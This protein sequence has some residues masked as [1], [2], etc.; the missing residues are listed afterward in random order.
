MLL[1]NLIECNYFSQLTT[2]LQISVWPL[3]ETVSP[4]SENTWKHC[5]SLLFLISGVDLGKMTLVQNMV[6][7]KY[8]SIQHFVSFVNSKSN[9]LL[10][11]LNKKHG[12]RIMRDN[13]IHLNSRCCHFPLSHSM[14]FCLILVVMESTWHKYIN[15]YT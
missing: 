9:S 13:I 14:T 10:W 3:Y 7:R 6:Q 8:L 5:Q 12:K 4:L 15:K 11:T 1:N 2:R